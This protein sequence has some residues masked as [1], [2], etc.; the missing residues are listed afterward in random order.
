MSMVRLRL[1]IRQTIDVPARTE[2]SVVMVAIFRQLEILL[3][4]EPVVIGPPERFLAL[5]EV[6]VQEEQG[7]AAVL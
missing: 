2:I 7:W 3:E 5:Q 1:K 6:P 4:T